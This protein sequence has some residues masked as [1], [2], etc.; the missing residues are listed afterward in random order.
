MTSESP[1][2]RAGAPIPSA[3]AAR[4]LHKLAEGARAEPWSFEQFAAT[5][6]KTEVDSH[7]GQSR[8]K[9]A[10]FPRKTLEEFDF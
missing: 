3:A 9:A 10:R 8:I 5:L 4:A 7:C 2:D 1:G 6:L